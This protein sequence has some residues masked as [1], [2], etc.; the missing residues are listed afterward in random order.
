MQGFPDHISDH[1]AQNFA[2]K[3]EATIEDEAWSFED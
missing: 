1:A 2:A 3:V